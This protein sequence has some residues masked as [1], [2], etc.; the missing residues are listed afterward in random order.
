MKVCRS[1]NVGVSNKFWLN[2]FLYQ[3]EPPAAP[4]NQLL[5]KALKLKL[6]VINAHIGYRVS[7]STTILGCKLK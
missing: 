2:I 6:S 5:E 4:V 7:R 1:T 3:A